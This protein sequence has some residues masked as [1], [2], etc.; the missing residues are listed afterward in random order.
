MY[1]L[2]MFGKIIYA[3]N[4][5][6]VL[7]PHWKYYIKRIVTHRDRQGYD[8]SKRSTPTLRELTLANSFCVEHPVQRLFLAI[9]PFE[10]PYLW[11]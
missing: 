5:T 3:P 1:D 4:N 10:T 2:G 6:T 8:V 7:R 11:R 9:R